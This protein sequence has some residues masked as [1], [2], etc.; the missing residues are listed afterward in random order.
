[1][2]AKDLLTIKIGELLAKTDEL[3][4]AN[5]SLY[6]LTKENRKKTEEIR[7]TK[8]DLTESERNLIVANDKLIDINEKFAMTNKELADVNRELVVANE[9]I[10]NLLVKQKEF[11]DITAHELR[12]P[13]QAIY[14][15]FELI[16]M[17]LPSLLKN[18]LTSQN[19]IKNE[20]NRLIEDNQRLNQFTNRLVSTYRN[21]QRLEKL[22]NSILDLVKKDSN[23]LLLRKES[24]NLNEKNKEHHY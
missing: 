23:R 16:E 20:F 22:V 19:N 15:N 17:D 10:K 14:G 13:I 21:L 6:L 5:E 9:Q 18:S 4:E 24:F 7:K 3:R 8:K 12:T 11:L 1:M 2:N